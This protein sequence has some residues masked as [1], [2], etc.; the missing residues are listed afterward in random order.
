MYTFHVFL[1][2]DLGA[3][4]KMGVRGDAIAQFDWSV[5]EI[6]KA[7]EKYHLLDNTLIVISSDNGPVVDDGY[8]DRAEELLNGHQPAGPFR[9]NKYSSFE[10]GTAI[11][12][13]VSGRIKLQRIKNQMSFCRRSI[14][15]HHCSPSRSTSSKGKCL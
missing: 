2:N 4:T 1:T 9:G 10:G 8:Q 13:I 6:V 7:L 5:G 11:P 12:V 15:L 3:K 14:G